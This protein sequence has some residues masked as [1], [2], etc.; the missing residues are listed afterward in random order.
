MKYQ[1]GK[2]RFYNDN[3]EG[4]NDVVHWEV[5]KIKQHQDIRL[6]F[7]SVNSKFK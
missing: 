1:I 2:E 6:K 7:I 4:R 5:L 3:F